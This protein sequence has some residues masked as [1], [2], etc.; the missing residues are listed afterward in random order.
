[1]RRSQEVGRIAPHNLRE[2][3]PTDLERR[4]VQ[5]FGDIPSMKHRR[6]VTKSPGWGPPEIG[7]CGTLPDVALVAGDH[8]PGAG[9]VCGAVE[10]RLEID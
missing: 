1:M 4:V 2:V 5:D 10:G 3:R 8:A 6:V 9:L 7:G